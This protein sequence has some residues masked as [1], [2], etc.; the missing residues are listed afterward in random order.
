MGAVENHSRNLPLD[1]V[2]AHCYD[3]D[4]DVMTLTVSSTSTNGGTVTVSTGTITYTPVANF[5]GTDAFAYTVND[6]RGAPL[7]RW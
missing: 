4:D 6:G 7:Q 3:Q 1:K 5:T 2:Q